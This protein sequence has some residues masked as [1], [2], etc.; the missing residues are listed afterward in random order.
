MLDD[1]PRCQRPLVCCQDR[2]YDSDNMEHIYQASDLASKRRELMNAARAGGAQIRD[3]DGTGLVLLPQSRYDLLRAMQGH[4][5]KLVTLEAAL[6][7]PRKE[8][9][10]Q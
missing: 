8:R 4:L 2:R 9:R 1:R 10:S 3:T 7:R 5:A 6:D